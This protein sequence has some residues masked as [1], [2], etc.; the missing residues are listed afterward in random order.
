MDKAYVAMNTEVL[1]SKRSGLRTQAR[2]SWGYQKLLPTLMGSYLG[3]SC[4][5]FPK[6]SSTK[7]SLC[8]ICFLRQLRFSVK[9]KTIAVAKFMGNKA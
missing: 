3:K 2:K 9:Q 4:H 8:L 7:A 1:K 5:G 6:R